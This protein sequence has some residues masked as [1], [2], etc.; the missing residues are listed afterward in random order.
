MQAAALEW[1][2]FVSVPADTHLPSHCVPPIP[3]SI[4]RNHIGDEGASALAAILKETQITHL[5]LQ[6]NNLGPEGGAA[7]A[8]GLKGNSTLQVLDLKRSQLGP[9]G[10]A[11]IAEGLKG[12]SML[13]SLNVAQNKITGDAAE[14]LATAVL[15]HAS[16]ARFCEIPLTSLRENSI[17]QVVHQCVGVP[18]AIVLS[19]LLPSAAALTSLKCAAAP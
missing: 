6:R 17:M 12:N 5:G 18:G 2:A 4:A 14:N 13:Q 15:E 9:E 11:A 19:K 3:R 8:E 10:G 16:M 7:L 1:F